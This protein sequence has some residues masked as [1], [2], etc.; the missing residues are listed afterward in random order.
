MVHYAAG[1]TIQAITVPANTLILAAGFQVTDFASIS[2]T[3]ATVTLGFTGGV[4]DEF[5]DALDI[6]GASDGDGSTP[7]R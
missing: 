4:V 1:D 7:A 5:A 3:T 2:G 6:I